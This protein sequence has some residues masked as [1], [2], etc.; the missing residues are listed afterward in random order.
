MTYA[1][2][3]MTVELVSTKYDS[4]RNTNI[5]YFLSYIWQ[6][7]KHITHIKSERTWSRRQKKGN[8]GTK[9]VFLYIT[10]LIHNIYDII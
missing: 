6:S 9:Y 2:K 1:G 10:L 3:W 4:L 8:E 5:A 7:L